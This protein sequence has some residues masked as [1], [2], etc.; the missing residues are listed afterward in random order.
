MQFTRTFGLLKL[1]SR[2]CKTKGALGRD[3]DGSAATEED[4]QHTNPAV[5]PEELELKHSITSKTAALSR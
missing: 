2:T 5:L 4:Q 3:A 1:S